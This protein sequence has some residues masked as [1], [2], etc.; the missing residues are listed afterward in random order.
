VKSQAWVEE[1]VIGEPVGER[2]LTAGAEGIQIWLPVEG[3]IDVEK[4]RKKIE[5]QIKKLTDSLN[6]SQQKMANPNFVQRA[7]PE[8]VEKERHIIAEALREIELL[9]ARLQQFG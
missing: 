3:L 2:T 5:T 1:I 4:Q 7:K 8:V 6:K 9:T